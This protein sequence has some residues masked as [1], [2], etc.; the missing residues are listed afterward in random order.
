MSRSNHLG[1]GGNEEMRSY[2][3]KPIFQNCE[4][5]TYLT[6]SKRIPFFK[7]LRRRGCLSRKLKRIIRFQ[8]KQSSELVM[9]LLAISIVTSFG[10]ANTTHNLS[11]GCIVDTRVDTIR[12]RKR[13]CSCQ[14]TIFSPT[15]SST[16]LYVLPRNK[17]GTKR[18]YILELVLSR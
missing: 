13:M 11:C 7:I 15:R 10:D 16:A 8:D 4:E 5:G 3:L 18:L 6:H 1:I 14:S 2:F 9:T 12:P 17:R